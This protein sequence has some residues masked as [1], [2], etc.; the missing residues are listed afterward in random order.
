MDAGLIRVPCQ[1]GGEE[2]QETVLLTRGS[3]EASRASKELVLAPGHA[4]M[5]A[6][7]ARREA[8]RLR[9]EARALKAEGREAR[10]RR[11]ELWASAKE[12]QLPVDLDAARAA[13]EARVARMWLHLDDALWELLV[14]HEVSVEEILARVMG[15]LGSARG[16]VAEL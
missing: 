16:D 14:I 12:A 3:A 4:R 10:L 7:H 13:L 6:P 1:C 5:W 15:S 2:C 11:D 9:E 8:R